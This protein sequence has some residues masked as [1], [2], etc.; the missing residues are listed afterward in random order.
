MSEIV[1]VNIITTKR[2][3]NLK[4]KNIF[5]HKGM[6]R[7]SLIIL[8][9]NK[10]QSS[11]HTENGSKFEVLSVYLT[12]PKSL[13]DIKNGQKREFFKIGNQK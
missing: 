3:D 10:I 1:L 12:F 6:A 13:L 2:H 8:A 7:L 11:D 9:R 4:T 5:A